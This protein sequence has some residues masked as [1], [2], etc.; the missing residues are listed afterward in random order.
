MFCLLSFLE[1]CASPGSSLETGASE[2]HIFCGVF[3]SFLTILSFMELEDNKP[4]GVEAGHSLHT[5]TSCL[6]KAKR[7]EFGPGTNVGMMKIL[8]WLLLKLRMRSR[9]RGAEFACPL[10]GNIYI[11]KGNLH[12]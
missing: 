7:Q 3:N 1:G 9:L 11:C 12:L 8:G 2:E 6:I 10:L 5:L 4:K